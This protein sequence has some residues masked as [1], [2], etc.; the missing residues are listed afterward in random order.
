MNQFSPFQTSPTQTFREKV[1]GHDAVFRKKF[2]MLGTWLNLLAKKS[3]EAEND[4]M[5]ERISK[6]NSIDTMLEVRLNETIDVDV[7]IYI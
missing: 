6:R 2:Q 5:I 4:A 7:K 3:K 1:F